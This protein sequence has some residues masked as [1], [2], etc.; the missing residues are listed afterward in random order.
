[1]NHSQF[2]AWAMSLPKDVLPCQK[3][4]FVAICCAFASAGTYATGKGIRQS[5]LTIADKS[6]SDR[7]VVRKVINWLEQNQVIVPVG[8]GHLNITEYDL[9]DAVPDSVTF[10][11]IVSLLPEKG[12]TVSQTGMSVGTSEQSVGTS[13][14]SVGTSDHSVG[15]SDTH[16]TTNTNINTTTNTNITNPMDRR[17]M[18]SEAGVDEDSADQSESDDPMVAG[19]TPGKEPTTSAVNKTSMDSLRSADSLR[20]STSLRSSN[21]PTA[22]SVTSF[23]PQPTDHTKPYKVNEESKLVD[24]HRPMDMP[25]TGMQSEPNELNRQ[26]IEPLV[27]GRIDRNIDIDLDEYLKE[28][29][30]P[31]QALAFDW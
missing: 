16:N 24:I 9:A 28:V 2:I 30:T 10:T 20:S 11:Q 6:G 29:V 22:V 23:L 5:Q 31:A 7:R 8:T 25:G 15:T 12:D 1:M 17:S 26:S 13:E 19:G 18:A 14:H 27:G 21:D 3:T 4:S